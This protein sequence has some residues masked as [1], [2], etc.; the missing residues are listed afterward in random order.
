MTLLATGN[1]V[2]TV[3]P[4]ELITDSDG[5]KFTRP[6]AVGIV[7][8]ASVQPSLGPGSLGN[9][10]KDSDG[11][12]YSISR[13]RLRLIGWQGGELGAQSQVEWNGKRYSIEGE[14][15]VYGGSRR[16]ART[17]YLMVRS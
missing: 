9:R 3:F 5:N 16:T 1:T 4:E 17:E 14:P 13:Y 10:E 7:C 6:S 12:Y 15:I 8:K 11:G 2:V